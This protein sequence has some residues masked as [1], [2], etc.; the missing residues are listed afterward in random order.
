MYECHNMSVPTLI[1]LISVAYNFPSIYFSYL[2][3]TDES[4]QVVGIVHDKYEE[5]LERG[6]Q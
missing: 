1:S 6:N 4:A 2:Y 5:K 3:L